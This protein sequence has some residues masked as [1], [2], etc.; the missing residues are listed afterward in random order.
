MNFTNSATLAASLLG[1]SFLTCLG[2]YSLF[3]V[4]SFAGPSALIS[5]DILRL[6]WRPVQLAIILAI[7]TSTGG[8]MYTFGSAKALSVLTFPDYYLD[9]AGGYT[10]MNSFSDQY[11]TV[12]YY[13]TMS[14]ALCVGGFLFG[15]GTVSVGRTLKE[16]RLA[17][18]CAELEG[19]VSKASSLPPN[20][21]NF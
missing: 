7:G 13:N 17:R 9:F 2:I 14:Y 12:N 21:T 10:F 8:I 18:A 16:R 15:I 5:R 20:S 19:R 11:N 1:C 4:S 6:W 3:A